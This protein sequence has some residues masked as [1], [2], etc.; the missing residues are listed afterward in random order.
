MVSNVVKL[1]ASWQDK[2]LAERSRSQKNRFDSAQPTVY[3]ND[4]GMLSVSI[5]IIYLKIYSTECRKRLFSLTLE[6]P[7]SGLLRRGRSQSWNTDNTDLYG[8]Q[9]ILFLVENTL[10]SG[11]IFMRL[12][13]SIIRVYQSNPCHLCA[14]V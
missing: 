10:S 2:P 6:K 5:E 3:L 13:I 7:Y 1:S 8:F 12:K 14:I 9:R 4:I 11:N